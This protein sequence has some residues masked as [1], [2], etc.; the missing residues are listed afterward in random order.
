MIDEVC[1]LELESDQEFVYRPRLFKGLYGLFYATEGFATTGILMFLP[2]YMADILLWPELT[3]G[4]LLAIGAIPGYLKV[5]YGFA[6]DSKA[7]GG[8]GNRRPYVLISLPLIV[9]GWFILPFATEAILFTAVVFITTLGFYIGDVAVDAW[10]V[11]VTPAS[12]RGSMMGLGW[13]AQG[14]ASVMGV[15]VTLIVAP[16]YGYPTAFIILGCI[17]GIGALVWFVFAKEKPI[18]DRL[19]FNDTVNV[20]RGELKHSYL[21]LAFLSFI[22]AGFIFGVGTNFMTLFYPAVIGP[23]ADASIFVLIWSVFFFIGGILGGFAYDR[24]NDYRKGVYLIAPIYAIALFLLGFN[25]AGNMDLAYATTIFF[26]IAC[27]MTTAA[28]MGFAMHITPPAIAG[29]MFAI[30]TSLVNLGQNGIGNVFLG[31][32]VTPFGYAFVFTV[33]AIVAIPVII[34]AKF[35]IPPWKKNESQGE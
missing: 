30:F 34:L 12:D 8:L 23:E 31:Y 13:G 5:V 19:S 35:I 28:I 6:S 16:T 21:W 24:I 4:I 9:G 25:S 22:G 33:G 18:L 10:A 14:I 11:E 32:S 17:G 7:I 20:L 2:V 29:T 1:K 26:G 15:L 27:G 3:I